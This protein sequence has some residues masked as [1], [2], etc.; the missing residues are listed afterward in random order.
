MVGAPQQ[1]QG[2]AQMPQQQQ[3]IGAPGQM[4]GAAPKNQMAGNSAP[5]GGGKNQ[6]IAGNAAPMQHKIQYQVA[7]QTGTGVQGKR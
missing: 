6:G 3:Q 7:P 5:Q 2:V 4:Q 1:R